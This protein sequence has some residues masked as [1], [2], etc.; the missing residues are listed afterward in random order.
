MTVD[1]WRPRAYYGLNRTQIALTSRGLI[2]Y[3]PGND[4]HRATVLG[5]IVAAALRADRPTTARQPRLNKSSD[6][7]NPE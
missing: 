7:P 5:K 3:V 2:E 6:S 4:I 1:F